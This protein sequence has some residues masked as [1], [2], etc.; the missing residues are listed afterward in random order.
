M[1][2]ISRNA[3]DGDGKRGDVSALK[4]ASGCDNVV[5]EHKLALELVEQGLIER[6]HPVMLGG[7]GI[8]PRSKFNAWG[9]GSDAVVSSIEAKLRE[10]LANQ[11]LGEPLRAQEGSK[12]TLSTLLAYQGA[13]VHDAPGFSLQDAVLKILGTGLSPAQ[14]AAVLLK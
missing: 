6:V 1:P 7:D 10:H 8:I 5:L 3:L 12:Q 9:R 13:F 14:F 4:P 11:S 2:I